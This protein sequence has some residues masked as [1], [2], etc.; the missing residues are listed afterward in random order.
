MLCILHFALRTTPF[1]LCFYFP[2]PSN[3]HVDAV[4]RSGAVCRGAQSLRP[5]SGCHR[6]D[7]VVGE[8]GAP[9]TARDTPCRVRAAR[10]PSARSGG[11][12]WRPLLPAG[13]SWRHRHAVASTRRPRAARRAGRR[14]PRS[15][16]GLESNA[17]RLARVD[18]RLPGGHRG[19]R[20][21]PRLRGCLGCRR[22]GR[23]PQDLD[24]SC[25]GNA[26]VGD[27]LAAGGGRRR[28]AHRG[29][30]RAHRRAAGS[31]EDSACRD[32]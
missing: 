32:G 20:R 17:L 6:R 28:T 18:C 3:R 8:R 16:G 30:L 9:A 26:A 5:G 24:S 12:V 31:R 10:V 29:V 2:D 23:G 4:V 14:D 21:S 19:D 13:R 25:A 11:A 22:H 1:L 15:A 7:W 27:C